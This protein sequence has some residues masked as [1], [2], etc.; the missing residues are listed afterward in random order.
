[1]IE[2]PSALT[3]QKHWQRPS[4]A[5]ID[6]LQGVPTGFVADAL[7][8]SGALSI[9]IKPIGDGRDLNCVLAGP[10]ITANN[11]PADILATLAALQFVQ[12]GDVLV[13]LVL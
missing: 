9:D 4:K 8:G 5:Q 12:P 6:A 13:V 3:V 7:G 10:A 2:E 1:M 11:A